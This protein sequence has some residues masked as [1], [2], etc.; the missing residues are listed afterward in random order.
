M[1]HTGPHSSSYAVILTIDEGNC[2]R[3]SLLCLQ[4]I[5]GRYIPCKGHNSRGS[6]PWWYNQ[7]LKRPGDPRLSMIATHD[8]NSLRVFSMAGL[9]CSALQNYFPRLLT[10]PS[11]NVGM[12]FPSMEKWYSFTITLLSTTVLPFWGLNVIL[13]HFMC[14]SS[15]RNNHLHPVTEGVVNVRS[16]M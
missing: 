2:W 10:G 5:W 8:S 16:F 13:A 3:S 11:T 15:P 1:N 6:T 4:L 12:G 9:S 14:L 7:A